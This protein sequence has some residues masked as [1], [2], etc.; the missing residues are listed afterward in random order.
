MAS[1]GVLDILLTENACDLISFSF[2]RFCFLHSEDRREKDYE[3]IHLCYRRRGIGSRQGNYGSVA[4]TAAQSQGAE[5]GGTE[6]GSVYQHRSGHYESLS[7]I[8]I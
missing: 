5:G 3:K 6:I 4:G 2:L 7:L 1:F 8:H